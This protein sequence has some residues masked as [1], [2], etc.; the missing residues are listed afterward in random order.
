MAEEKKVVKGGFRATLALIIAI[1]AIIISIFA[2][3]NT[4]ENNSMRKQ[5]DNLKAT[6][7]QMK[8]ETSQKL[9]EVRQQT[10]NALENLGKSLKEEKEKN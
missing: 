4:S 6:V 7:Q 3:N 8:N 2:Y 10:A 5:I 9:D 1:I